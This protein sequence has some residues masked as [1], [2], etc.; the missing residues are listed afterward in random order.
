LKIY[1]SYKYIAKTETQMFTGV[2]TTVGAYIT[3]LYLSPPSNFD[4]PPSPDVKEWME[5]G[6]ASR[7]AAELLVWHR[8]YY[9][10]SRSP[11]AH[12]LMAA[13]GWTAASAEL[14]I[15]GYE[16]GPDSKYPNKGY[17]TTWINPV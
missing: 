11:A 10:N 1:N 3:L 8:V 9:E 16:P 15:R 7:R 12:Q 13:G 14:S 4:G 6:K 17:M 5:K 2:L